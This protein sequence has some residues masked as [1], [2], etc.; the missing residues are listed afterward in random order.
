MPGSCY[1]DRRMPIRLS[2]PG[3]GP[4]SRGA[5]GQAGAGPARRV[6]SR[7]LLALGVWLC[8]Q[9]SAGVLASQATPPQRPAVPAAAL[10]PLEAA[11]AEALQ[12]Y[13]AALESLD[14]EQVK[15]IQPAVDSEGLKRAFREMREL[16][17]TIDSIKVLSAD[18]GTTRVSFR[19]TQTLIP[20]TGTKQTN[21]VTRVM[22]LRKQEA[23][24][25][26]DGF[27]R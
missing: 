20:K 15:K 17:V 4:A 7:G 24:W 9:A 27:E 6:Y 16:K 23:A 25:V 14:A 10:T 26:I 22:R 3:P 1:S 18:G 5:L 13:S 2:I 19:V 21:T 8:L 11:V 12:Q